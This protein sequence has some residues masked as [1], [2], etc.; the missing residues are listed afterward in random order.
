MKKLA[1][2]SLILSC[3]TLSA[4]ASVINPL[5]GISIS[6]SVVGDVD[7]G[8]VSTTGGS[9]QPLLITTTPFVSWWGGITSHFNG[10][11]LQCKFTLHNTKIPVGSMNIRV[12]LPHTEGHRLS[13]TIDNVQS[14]S[15]YVL[16][17]TGSKPNMGHVDSFYNYTV[18]MNKAN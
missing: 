13:A 11:N 14:M 7:M 9:G 5:S 17:T 4:V 10:M 3:I 2:L 15:G 16:T 6:S 12:W 8:C 1:G 18:T